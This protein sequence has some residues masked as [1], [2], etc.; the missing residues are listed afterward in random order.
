MKKP[1]AR[2][3]RQWHV[4]DRRCWYPTGEST[5]DCRE[6]IQPLGRGVA[7]CR[8]R[9]IPRYVEMLR[10]AC[11]Q[12]GWDAEAFRCYRCRIEYPFYG[13]QVHMLFERSPRPP[14]QA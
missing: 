7:S 1:P 11:S 12:R 14:E 13:A 8:I 4:C 6:V 10:R 3:P 5:P 2:H 9:E